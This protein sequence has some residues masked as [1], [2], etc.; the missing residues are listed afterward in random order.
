MLHAQPTRR[1][2]RAALYGEFIPPGGELLD[3]MSSWIS[4]LP[5]E[6]QYRRVV[7]LG[8]NEAEL[9]RNER[10]RRVRHLRLDR[11]PDPRKKVLDAREAAKP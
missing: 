8:M 11:L 10:V 6:V 3:L 1:G 4:N 7:G 2:R 5:S 9:R